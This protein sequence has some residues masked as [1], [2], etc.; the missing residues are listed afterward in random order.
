MTPQLGEALVRMSVGISHAWPENKQL[1]FLGVQ[2]APTQGVPFQLSATVIVPDATD[3]EVRDGARALITSAIAI[4]KSIKPRM[5]LELKDDAQIERPNLP[6]V[7]Y[8]ELAMGA[9]FVNPTPLAESEFTDLES[10]SQ[11]YQQLKS[12]QQRRTT[13]AAYW[14]QQA[15]LAPDDLS[16]FST[17]WIGLEAISSSGGSFVAEA[18]VRKIESVDAAIVAADRPGLKAK[19]EQLH[20]VRS[21]I[22]HLGYGAETVPTIQSDAKRTLSLLR[23]LVYKTLGV[24]FNDPLDFLN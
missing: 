20:Q 1:D 8:M 24:P 22:F 16:R 2:F 10:V 13:N 4:I 23:F 14:L 12:N 6:G 15:I 3:D 21:Q 17:A 7:G 5:H 18:I 11:T 19:I 9:N